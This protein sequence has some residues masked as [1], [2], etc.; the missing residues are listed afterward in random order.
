MTV[1]QSWWDKALKG[2]IVIGSWSMIAGM[3]ICVANIFTRLF[4]IPILGTYEFI[5]LAAIPMVCFA[6]VYTAHKR[7]NVSMELVYEM[8]PKKVQRIL[9]FGNAMLA[10]IFFFL[11]TW[12]GLV[13][14]AKQWT[15]KEATIVMRWPVYPFRILFGIVMIF[16]AAEFFCEAIDALRGRRRKRNNAC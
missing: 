12:N 5:E 9:L 7:G 8:L 4:G 10:S 14:A 13:Y 3:G 15:S 6:M 11:I 2:M 1:W 16:V